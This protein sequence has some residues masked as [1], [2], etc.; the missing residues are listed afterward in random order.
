M[1]L[2]LVEWRLV[3]LLR[4]ELRST[5]CKAIVLA[6]ERQP[7]VLPQRVERWFRSLEHSDKIHI[8]SLVRTER[9]ELSLAVWKTA[10]LAINTKRAFG[11]SCVGLN[12]LLLFTREVCYRIH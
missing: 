2:P 12:P 11:G 7:L 9:L 10:V 8:G 3:E 1:T 5:A 4:I 6:I